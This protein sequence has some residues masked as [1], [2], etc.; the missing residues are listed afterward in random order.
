MAGPLSA[1]HLSAV[2]SLVLQGQE[3]CVLVSSCGVPVRTHSLLLALLS[4]SLASL[5]GEVGQGERGVSLPLSLPQVRVLVGLLQGQMDPGGREVVEAAR[6]LGLI[7]PVYEGAEG[8]EEGSSRWK[9]QMGVEKSKILNNTGGQESYTNTAL[10]LEMADSGRAN[11]QQ[12]DNYGKVRPAQ[13]MTL[14]E[15]AAL[16]D[17]ENPLKREEVEQMT[18]SEPATRDSSDYSDSSEDEEDTSELYGNNAKPSIHVFK[19]GKPKKEPNHKPHQ[20]S[21]CIVSYGTHKGLMRHML[22]EHNIPIKCDKCNEHFTEACL[23]K[24]HNKKNHPKVFIC[25]VC[26][27]SKDDK[28]KLDYHIEAEHQEDIAC[29]QCGILCRTQMLLT[30]HI[31]RDHLEKVFLEKVSEKCAKCDYR[32]HLPIEM[33][34]HFK[35]RHTDATKETCQHCGEVFKGLRKHLMRTGCGGE[36]V[37]KK[38]PCSSC[39]K[40]FNFKQALKMHVKKA[41]EKVKDKHC[42]YCSYETY[43]SFNLKLHVTKMHLGSKLEK[44]ACPH[45]TKV[46]TNLNYHINIMHNEHFVVK[47]SGKTA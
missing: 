8:R 28:R 5:L 18:L 20:C 38:E 9:H 31:K 47:D 14:Q 27:I 3:D 46:T 24:R 26:D 1:S 19:N 10:K 29:P 30:A 33:K 12:I 2:S 13:M 42:Q 37:I 44:K 34:G 32:T 40:V 17:R 41:H 23:L 25:H 6:L 45:C 43:S 22:N 11:L 21:S 4:P 36:M 35:R 7:I 15:A 16:L 39:D